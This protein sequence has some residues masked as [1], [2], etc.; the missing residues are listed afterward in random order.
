MVEAR[1][2]YPVIPIKHWWALRNKFKQS[3]PNS[4]TGGYVATVL[5]MDEKSAKAN[6]I[7][8][9]ITFGI[10]DQD[11]VPTDQAVKWRDDELYP[12]FCKDL[13]QQIYPQELIDALPGPSVDSAAV[14]R[15]F[16]NKT[17]VGLQAAN[18]MS[19]VYKLLTEADPTKAEEDINMGLAQTRVQKVKPTS[20]GKKADKVIPSVSQ[21]KPELL[22]E[23]V[24]PS[25]H[26]DFSPSL[27]IDVQIHI[28]PDASVTQIEQIFASMAKY[29][30]KRTNTYGE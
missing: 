2:T 19:A 30:F 4:V 1:K 21:R 27:H 28:S 13:R 29:L 17:G 20:K 5:A 7:P 9:L 26:Q 16:M 15:W 24:E 25:L 6:I 14:Q 11:G 22:S 8:A 3:I 23:K 12:E 18:K 10:I